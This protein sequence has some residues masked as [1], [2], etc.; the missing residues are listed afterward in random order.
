MSAHKAKTKRLS[1]EE[2]QEQKR[3]GEDCLLEICGNN[4]GRRLELGF[5]R[6]IIGR[7][8]TCD[9]QIESEAVSRRHTEI[10][11]EYGERVLRD[12][13]S[14]NG[15][16]INNVSVER[17]L[18]RNGDLIKIGDT[19]LKFLSGSNIETHFHEEIFRMVITDGLTMVS[20]KRHLAEE[21]S[22]EVWRASRH[23]RALSLI[24]FD[25][26]HFK[27]VN[28]KFG[29]VAGDHILREISALIRPRIR[30]DEL[31][32]RYGGEEFMVILPET[33]C[34][35][36]KHFAESLR[37]MVESHIFF[38]EGVW[39]PITISVGVAQFDQDS[40]P[41]M[42]AFIEAVDKALYQAKGAGRNRVC[43]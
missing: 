33:E 25:L 27:D 14:T 22:R 43:V 35:K 18:L 21:L 12:L 15:T 1:K 4:L 17:S 10:S 16:F 39:I 7:D 42:E 6:L 23:G 5:S 3:R 40:H 2:L 34:E 8:E 29:H 30:K 28:D 9:V 36:A 24:M 37:V 13:G 38:Y 11:I 32:G 20:N 19:V 26:D 41:T 31:F